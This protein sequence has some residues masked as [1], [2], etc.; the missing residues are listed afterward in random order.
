MFS[1]NLS[2]VAFDGLFGAANIIYGK[3]MKAAF[4]F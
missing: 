4:I 2:L 3:K 1:K